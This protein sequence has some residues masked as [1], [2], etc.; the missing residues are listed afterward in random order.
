[1]TTNIN[2]TKHKVT[3]VVRHSKYNDNAIDKP[4]HE[5]ELITAPIGCP[6]ALTIK[7][8]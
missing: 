3:K 1:M 4:R 5:N 8:I 6:E 7:R 2:G